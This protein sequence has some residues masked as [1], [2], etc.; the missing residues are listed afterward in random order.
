MA[1]HKPAIRKALKHVTQ[2]LFRFREIH[3]M[4][5]PQ[6]PRR[7]LNP[8]LLRVDFPRVHVEEIGALLGEDYPD[9]FPEDPRW[10]QPEIPPA[11]PRKGKVPKMPKV[12]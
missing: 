2:P 5:E 7:I 3:V 4:P 10:D 11:A 6:R 8:G 9:T 1:G 12:P